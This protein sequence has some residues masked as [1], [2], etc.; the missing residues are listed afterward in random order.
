MACLMSH[1][2]E[3][4]RAVAEQRVM[5]KHHRFIQALIRCPAHL[6]VTLRATTAYGLEQNRQG[7]W[8]PHVITLAPIQHEA[9]PY[10]FDLVG[11]LE[12]ALSTYCLLT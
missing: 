10:A 11:R 6:I 9:F 7:Q 3:T 5:P 4:S 8:E 2:Q 12:R 1:G